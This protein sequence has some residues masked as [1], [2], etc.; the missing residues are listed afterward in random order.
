MIK[1]CTCFHA[2]EQHGEEGCGV[3]SIMAGPCQ[4]EYKAL[5]INQKRKTMGLPPLEDGDQTLQQY[6]KG[7]L[8]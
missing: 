8:Q 6:L 7:E 5:T 4:C 1:C 2:P 3:V